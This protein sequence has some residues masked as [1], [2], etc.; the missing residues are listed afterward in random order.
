MKARYSR[1]VV[2]IGSN[3]ITQKNGLPDYGRIRHLIEQLVSLRKI[4]IE[5]ILVSSG[6]V[7]FGRSLIKISDRSRPIAVRQLLSSIGQVKLINTYSSLLEEHNIRC[8]Q[9]LVT[10]SDFR[11]R[12]HYLNMQNCLHILMHEQ[13]VPI[14]NE[15]DVV[16]V[17]E[18]MFT[19]NDEL[20]G[21]IASMLEADAL[22]ILSNVDGIYNGDPNDASS[23][24]MEEI[25]HAGLD[26]SAFIQTSKSEFGRGGMITKAAI[27][28]RTAKLG[29]AVHI[30]NGT[31][32]S[33]LERIISGEVLHT[34]FSPGKKKSRKKSWIAN[35]ENAASGAVYLNDGARIAL[36]SGK[37]T[38][39]LPIGITSLKGDFKKG[40]IIKVFDQEEQLIGLG[41]V[42]YDAVE[43]R[44]KIGSKNEKPLI[45][46]DYFYSLI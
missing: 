36:T 31:K 14:I 34:R 35:A 12:V 23:S 17:T 39:L 8:A 42:K 9:V 18:L 26:F 43:A 5:I 19:D 40:D 32:D 29:I 13:V 3:V 16:S 44:E 27:A 46:Y 24:I 10:K 4:G 11:D 41:I 20:S 15:N 25:G 33:V 37:A 28:Q 7:A 6:A 45:H 22:I 2:K 38:S 1:I 30:A 21:L